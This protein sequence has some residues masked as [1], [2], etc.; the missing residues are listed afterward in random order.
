MLFETAR[1]V[2]QTRDTPKNDI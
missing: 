1:S 2:L